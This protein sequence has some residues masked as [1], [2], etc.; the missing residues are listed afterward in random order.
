MYIS[1][2]RAWI[3]ELTFMVAKKFP[4]LYVY[5]LFLGGESQFTII[6]YKTVFKSKKGQEQQNWVIRHEL[7][8]C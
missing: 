1:A 2:S 4:Q 3:P 5:S 8:Q 7:D 6:I